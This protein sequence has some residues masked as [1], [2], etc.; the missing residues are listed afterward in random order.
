MVMP[1]GGRYWHYRYQFEGREKLISLG[2]Y[3]DVP[4]ES[5]RARRHA[6]RQFLEAGVDP[7]SQ[8]EALRRI[9]VDGI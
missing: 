2:C 9:S 4:L 1:K 5:A 7:A 3:R 6:A 8:R